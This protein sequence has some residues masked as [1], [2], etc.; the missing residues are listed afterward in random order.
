M[1]DNLDMSAERPRS[2][3]ATTPAQ[4]ATGEKRTR[5][6]WIPVGTAAQ[7]RVVHAERG[8]ARGERTRRQ[9]LDAARTV[10]EQGGYL[11]VGVEEIVTEAGV[12][13]GT[14]Y[15]YFTSKLEVF[16]ALSNEVGTLVE[17]ATQRP[18]DE[19]SLDPI[20]ALCRANERYL[21]VYQ[22][23]ARI[24]ALG[25]QLSHIDDDLH[26]SQMERRRR[27]LDRT[28]SLIR[29]WQSRGLA[30]PTIDP[31]TAAVGLVYM[32]SN[33]CYGLFVANDEGYDVDRALETMNTIWIRTVDLRR[34]PNRAWLGRDSASA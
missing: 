15:T 29:H 2:R 7:R 10:F 32:S 3:K 9:I 31:V 16:I 20:E 19:R 30:D 13:R 6:G 26:Q 4:A 27:R 28:S 5:G 24:Y 34:K 25:D 11:D 21:A 17:Q 14:F 18:E 8:N 12:A 23:N 22:E 1:G 33:L